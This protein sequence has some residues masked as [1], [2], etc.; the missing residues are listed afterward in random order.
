MR[1]R[2]LLAVTA[3]SFSALAGTGAQGLD[4]T[5]NDVGLA[6]GNK[7][8]VTGLRFNFRDRGLEQI[9]GLNATLWMPYE[10]ITG[11]VHGVALGLPLTGAANIRGIAAGVFGFGASESLT[12]IGVAGLGAGVGSSMK[13][14]LIA[15]VGAGIGSDAS[16]LIVGGLGAGVGSEFRGIG[17]G[18]L[19]FGIGSGMRGAAIGGL[20]VGIGNDM[21][22]VAIG[23]LGVGVG[24]S[25]RG[26]A[27]SVVGVGVGNDFRGIG[28]GGV[29]VG[30]GGDATGIVVGGVGVGVGRNLTGLAI[31]GAGIGAGGTIHGAALAIGGI[32]ASRIEGFTL[33]LGAGAQTAH[34]IVVAPLYFKIVSTSDM[35]G[36]FRGASV[37]SAWNRIQGTQHGLT[38]GLLNTARELH[39]VQ[40][41]LINVSDNGGKRLVLPLIAA[42]H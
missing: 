10:P 6:I 41:G 29:G 38:I 17:V 8:R 31:G 37:F 20:G 9:N 40:I 26:L 15:V 16:G 13:G 1:I 19:G 14:A 3:F 23:G 35:E 34:A 24:S 11:T 39:G 42:R 36:E 32:G 27:F 18:G 33:S 30:A 4:L 5:V 25:A 12:G 7:P 21:R 28:I 22:G 2:L